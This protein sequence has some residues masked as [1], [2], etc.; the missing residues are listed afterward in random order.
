MKHLP[1]LPFTVRTRAT[2]DQFVVVSVASTHRR[3]S[4]S[5]GLEIGGHIESTD[6]R[7]DPFAAP[8]MFVCELKAGYL[9]QF[10]GSD[11][12]VT[13]VADATHDDDANTSTVSFR[14][15][16]GTESTMVLCSTSTVIAAKVE[17]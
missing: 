6:C 1:S 2:G 8:R 7:V 13:V 14:W 4:L 10:D 11:L 3:H 15:D 5:F 16:D 12:I 17:G 9:M